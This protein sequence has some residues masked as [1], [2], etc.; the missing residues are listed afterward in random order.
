MAD[1]TAEEWEAL[2]LTMDLWREPTSDDSAQH[3]I[4]AHNAR[5]AALRA[6]VEAPASLAVEVRGDVDGIDEGNVWVAA[7]SW[8]GAHVGQRV[9]VRVTPEGAAG[10]EKD[11]G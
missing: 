2:N 8:P 5:V 1:I 4:D 10:E 3:L 7:P 11:R 6:K 9:T